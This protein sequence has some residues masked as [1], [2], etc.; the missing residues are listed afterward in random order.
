MS[1]IGIS[2]YISYDEATLSATALRLGIENK[3]TIQELER[4]HYVG[5]LFDK[6]RDNFKVP[7]K[8]N[9]FFRCKALNDAVGSTDRSFHRLG[10]AIDITAIKGTGITNED[11]FNFVRDKC[12]FTELINEYNFT[13]VHIALVKG[14]ESEKKV[15]VIK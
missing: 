5:R 7:I 11:I 12:E 13:W 4:M 10:A 14:R 1:K 3:P 8:V 15:K 6:I 9:S 2:K